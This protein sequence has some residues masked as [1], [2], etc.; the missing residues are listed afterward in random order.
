M[1]SVSGSTRVRYRAGGVGGA[2]NTL[3]RFSGQRTILHLVMGL[4]HLLYMKMIQHHSAEDQSINK[5]D[6][7]WGKK[8]EVYFNF[9]LMVCGAKPF[10]AQ[11]LLC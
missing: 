6:G 2:P 11:T 3:F 5:N 8:S 9:K 4:G 1:W 10:S 7:I